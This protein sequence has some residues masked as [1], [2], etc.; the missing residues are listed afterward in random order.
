MQRNWY[1]DQVHNCEH[2]LLHV[3]QFCITLVAKITL[4]PITKTEKAQNQKCPNLLQ[5]G[6]SN[7]KVKKNRKGR[8][9][10]KYT[11]N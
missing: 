1:G 9:T 4:K 11:L 3:L 6:F 7:L 5:T 8:G 10:G 2:F